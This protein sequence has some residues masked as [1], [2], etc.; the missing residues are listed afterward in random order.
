METETAN[1]VCVTIQNDELLTGLTRD[2]IRYDNFSPSVFVYISTYIMGTG[3]VFYSEVEDFPFYFC[4]SFL[5]NT[6]PAY[7]NI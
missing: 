2:Q 3:S 6:I 7:I 1:R 4:L 5:D